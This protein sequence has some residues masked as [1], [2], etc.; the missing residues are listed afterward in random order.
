MN[1]KEYCTPLNMYTAGYGMLAKVALPMFA[2]ISFL[3]YA[4]PH[5]GVSVGVAEGAGA[6]VGVITGVDSMI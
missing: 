3:S 5:G 1:P 6:V 2:G 4:C